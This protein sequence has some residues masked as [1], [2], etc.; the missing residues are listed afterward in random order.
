MKTKQVV[1]ISCL[2]ILSKEQQQGMQQLIAAVT[3]SGRKVSFW[4][5]YVY[6]GLEACTLTTP[7][8]Q[9]SFLYKLLHPAARLLLNRKKWIARLE[10]VYG[11]D[12]PEAEKRFT[13]FVKDAVNIFLLTKPDKFMV[14]NPNCCIRG[15]AGTIARG[16]GIATGGIEYGLLP[17]TFI[18]DRKGTLGYSAIY[19]Q[20]PAAAYEQSLLLQT[21]EQIYQKL[22][23]TTLSLYEQKAVQI[24][25]A[26]QAADAKTR[27][28]LLGIDE[29]D[30]SCYPAQYRERR[31][32]LPFHRN[33]LE[34]AIDIAAGNPQFQ[35]IFKPH[36]TRNKH[37]E[38]KLRDN[39]YT[40]HGNPDELIDWADVVVCSGSKMEL[41]VLLAGKPLVNMGAGL[42]YKKGCAY[43]VEHRRDTSQQISAAARYGLTPSMETAFKKNL[44]Y[45]QLHY[46]YNFNNTGN[47][48][49]VIEQALS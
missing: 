23:S 3:A 35:V 40:V 36:P 33:C 2:A 14:W 24:P 25:D 1:L 13:A 49:A 4:S 7:E 48:A 6:E 11:I 22:K 12:R 8:R 5:D 39:L 28:L 29:I 45:L 32:L 20:N 27:V 44:A 18:F 17:G 47:N 30:S 19:R 46:L 42:L 37:P 21:G 43:E 31:L 10:Q 15:I 38:E 41:S 16:M 9:K 34:Q 26:F